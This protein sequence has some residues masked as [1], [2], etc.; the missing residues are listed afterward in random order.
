LARNAYEDPAIVADFIASDGTSYLK[1]TSVEWWN[2]RSTGVWNITTGGVHRPSRPNEAYDGQRPLTKAEWELVNLPDG[3]QPGDVAGGRSRKQDN[4][5]RT[6]TAAAEQTGRRV[7]GQDLSGYSVRDVERLHEKWG[8][9]QPNSALRRAYPSLAGV[10]AA[11][12]EDRRQTTA[13]FWRAEKKRVQ[14]RRR[15]QAEMQSRNQKELE[16][17][18]TQ[19]VLKEIRDVTHKLAVVSEK[20][21]ELLLIQG[22]DLKQDLE[23]VIE[24]VLA[25]A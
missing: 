4:A 11:V 22:A 7:Y 8:D 6:Q 2:R 17:V 10:D 24:E 5:D 12:K 14:E 21:D 23:R 20:L 13:D 18:E 15:Y 19:V 16:K 25:D 9:A 3:V 1:P